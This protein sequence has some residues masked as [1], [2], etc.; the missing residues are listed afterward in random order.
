MADGVDHHTALLVMDFIDGAVTAH[1]Q[2][3]QA[4]E[5]ARERFGADGVEI[6]GQPADAPD[7]ATSNGLV[8]T[9]QLTGS[10]V[11]DAEACR[12]STPKQV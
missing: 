12:R 11:Q 8:E 10:G 6:P 3:E 5:V 7:D 9:R 4:C 1:S 2:F